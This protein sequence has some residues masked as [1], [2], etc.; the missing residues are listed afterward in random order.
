[1]EQI[2]TPEQMRLADKIAIESYGIP[3]EILMENAAR[4]A[5]EF[6]VDIFAETQV[7]FSV[8]LICGSG[9]NGGDGFALARHLNDFVVTDIYWIGK[10]EK[11]SPETKRNYEICKSIG[12]ELTHID[13]EDK[14]TE[15]NWNYDCIIDAMIG[16]GGSENIRGI[17]KDI[18]QIVNKIPAWKIAVDAPTGLNTLNGIAGED[19]FKADLTVTMYA[20]KLGQILADGPEQC[21]DIFVANLGAPQSIINEVAN[22]YILEECDLDFF[23]PERERKTS[24]FDYGRLVIIAGSKQFP[25]AGALAANAAIKSGA[26]LVEL[27]SEVL[28][29]AI[30]P[31]VIVYTDNQNDDYWKK[32]Y[33][34]IKQKCEKA[35]AVL[36]GPGLGKKNYLLFKDLFG[37]LIEAKPV[38]LDADAL[39][40]IDQSKKYN[41]NLILTP[42]LGEFASLFGEDRQK[43]DEN[44]YVYCKEKANTL[45]CIVH[46][47]HYPS[48]TSNGAQTFLTVNGNAG[49]ASGGSGDVLSGIVASL[50]VQGIEPPLA[51]AVGSYI[52]ASAGD[53]YKNKYNETTLTASNLIDALPFILNRRAHEIE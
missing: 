7:D 34:Y 6:L 23:F 51:M 40:L 37:T 14:L 39:L 9:N 41:Q 42:H 47:K 12:M 1:M 43:V 17:A 29:P 31:E 32:N 19:A 36:I 25:G 4:S 53:Y 52:H 20:K 28:H 38:I 18:L 45:N 27:F 13:N 26:G 48:I 22:T 10:E 11:M 33:E 2:L 8:L 21:G 15:L 46:L 35:D 50:V 44:A 30:L 5:F 16:V 3:G 49:M 24:K